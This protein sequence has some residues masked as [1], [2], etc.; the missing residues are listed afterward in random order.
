[1][2]YDFGF[3]A[4]VTK[5]ELVAGYLTTT[6]IESLRKVLDAGFKSGASIK[7][8]TE[9]VS[10]IGIKDLYRMEGGVVKKGAS[11][12][13]I[14]AKSAESRSPAIVRTEVTRIANMGAVREYKA[15]GV[16]KIRWVASFGERTC[17]ECEGLDN[18][19][20][21][22]GNVPEIPAHPLCRCTL[23]AVDEVKDLKQKRKI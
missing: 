11:G 15:A 12:L 18:Q 7:E 14:L 2:E 8:M 16:E 20:F 9:K 3:L 17:I 4:G 1:M 5:E 19:I 22:V 23:V 21:E 10:K 13:P 6:Q